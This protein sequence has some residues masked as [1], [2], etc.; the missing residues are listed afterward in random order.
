MAGKDSSDKISLNGGMLKSFAEAQENIINSKTIYL[1]HRDDILWIM[2]NDAIQ[3]P[4]ISAT[5]HISRGD[6]LLLAGFF[7]AKLRGH[8]VA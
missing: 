1:P 2:T 6:Q 3:H 7:S 5:L 4:G 8:Q